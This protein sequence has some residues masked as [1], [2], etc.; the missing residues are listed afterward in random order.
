MWIWNP[1]AN[2]YGVFN[3]LGTTGTN[4]VTQYIPSM[5][6]FFV[7]AET[8]ANIVMTNDIRSHMGTDYWM[9]SG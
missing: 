4:D 2:N 7:R 1:T 6:G 9:K 5:Q 8:N 3:S